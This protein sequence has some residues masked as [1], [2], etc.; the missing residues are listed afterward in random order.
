MIGITCKPDLDTEMRTKYD[1]SYDLNGFKFTKG[2]IS[3]YGSSAKLC[4]IIEL[5]VDLSD[6]TVEYK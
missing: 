6:C 1:W 2:K 3:P 4:N 5:T